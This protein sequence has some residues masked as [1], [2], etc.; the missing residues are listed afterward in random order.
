MINVTEFND[1]TC[2]RELRYVLE[3]ATDA[4]LYELEQILFGTRC[5]ILSYSF[6]F[7][8]FWGVLVLV[9]LAELLNLLQLF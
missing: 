9:W 6:Q 3:L 7:S 1:S 8:F 5:I 2:D 4:E